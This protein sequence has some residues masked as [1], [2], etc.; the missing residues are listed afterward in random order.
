[1]QSSGQKKWSPEDIERG[2]AA[3]LRL[4]TSTAAAAETG[5]AATTLRA[6][7]HRHPEIARKIRDAHE[8]AMRNLREEIASD[9]AAG[10]AE[11]I[12]VARRALRG[13]APVDA[14]SAAAILRA[15]ATVD[16]SLDKI[17][18]LDAGSP[19][20]ITDDRRSDAD[21]IR[22]IERKINDPAVQAAMERESVGA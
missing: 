21:L 3:W 18:R 12:L 19:T 1:M 20:E 14:K 2:L 13:E 22:D 5:I 7:K 17:S 16:M 10:V 8:R 6:R 15:L 11:A 9:A 4:G